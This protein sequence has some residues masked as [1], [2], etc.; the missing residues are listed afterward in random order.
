M[1]YII[2]IINISL[3]TI[4]ILTNYSLLRAESPNFP[5]LITPITSSPVSLSLGG[6]SIANINDPSSA[7]FNPASLALLSKT[8]WTIST[9]NAV[10]K[11][12]SQIHDEHYSVLDTQN[13]KSFHMGYCGLSYPFKINSK[14][15]VAA[16]SYHPKFSF[17][18]SLS[19]NQNDDQEM[20]DQRSWHLKQSGYMSAL[21]FSYGIKI[22]HRLYLGVSLN[23]WRDDLMDNSWKQDISMSGYRQNGSVRFDEFQKTSL[24][25]DDSGTN[26]DFGLLWKI[27]PQF[28]AGAIFQTPRS[29]D[30]TTNFSEKY[31]FENLIVNNT[32][33]PIN[34]NNILDDMQIPMVLG[35]GISYLMNE[36]CQ[37][38]IDFRQICWEKFQFS[39][40]QES[41]KQ[42]LSGRA[43]DTDKNLR[44]HILNMGTVYRLKKQNT[45]PFDILFRMG[46]SVCTDR[47]SV[48]PEPDETFG[49]GLGFAGKQ[50]DLDLGYQYQRYGDREQLILSDGLLNNNIRNN[51]VEASL[52]YRFSQ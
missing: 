6:T 37:I 46:F 15:M 34:P 43:E 19:L 4:F 8:Q 12:F 30:I 21:S 38:L 32:S 35:M 2:K 29:N 45:S 31:M 11:E 25:Y 48:H 41:E 26:I 24:S 18:R 49:F 14:N 5:F 9:Y 10:Q 16:I 13:V 23:F 44:V 39:N 22:Y 42:F 3:L 7:I 47:G 50:V 33:N 20:T 51:V 28:M 17:E 52:T 36:N 40:F 27:S 1:K